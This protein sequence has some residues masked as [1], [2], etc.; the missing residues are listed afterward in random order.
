MSRRQCRARTLLAD[1]I[2]AIFAVVGTGRLGPVLLNAIYSQV[3]R[4]GVPLAGS[5]HLRDRLSAT[6]IPRDNLSHTPFLS[7]P[8]PLIPGRFR[9]TE[10]VRF[11]LKR[12]D[13]FP[14]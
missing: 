3:T 2:F 7:Y 12:T 5:S 6:L 14:L 8:S 13:A 1:I 9:L 11:L 10:S 4:L